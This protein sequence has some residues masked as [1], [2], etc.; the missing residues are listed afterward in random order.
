MKS[1][2]LQQCLRL[3]GVW[4]ASVSV[5]FGGFLELLRGP[6][7]GYSDG[8]LRPQPHVRSGRQH[9]RKIIASVS[10]RGRTLTFHGLFY[11]P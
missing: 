8:H 2:L 3:G 1:L 4:G 6:L 5:W 11:S 7:E 9:R 10:E